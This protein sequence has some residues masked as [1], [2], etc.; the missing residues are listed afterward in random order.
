MTQSFAGAPNES[1]W[2]Q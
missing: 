1:N 2:I